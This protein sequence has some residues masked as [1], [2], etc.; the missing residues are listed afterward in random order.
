MPW[1]AIPFKP[2]LVESRLTTTKPVPKLYLSYLV[3]VN[4]ANFGDSVKS[5]ESDDPVK[6]CKTVETN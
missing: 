4:Q 3:L 1:V 2:L 5:G 6:S